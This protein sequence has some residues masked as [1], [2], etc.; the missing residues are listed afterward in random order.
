[1]TPAARLAELGEILASG[2]RRVRLSLD[3]SRAVERECAPMEDAL[4]PT[5]A[6][7]AR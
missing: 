3:G 1:M 7:T 5:H 6:E 4:D 2:I